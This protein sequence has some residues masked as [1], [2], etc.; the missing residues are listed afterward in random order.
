MLAFHKRRKQK[1]CDEVFQQ[2]KYFNKTEVFQQQ[3]KKT[4]QAENKYETK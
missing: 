3:Q 1:V 2:Q 4:T